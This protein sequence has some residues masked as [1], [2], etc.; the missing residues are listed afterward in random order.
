M[1]NQEKK[2]TIKDIVEYFK[3]EILVEGDLEQNIETNDIHRAGYELT[4]FFMDKDELKRAV[5]VMG[6]KESEYLSRLCQNR[7]DQI[8]DEYFSHKFPALVLSS[9]VKDIE[10]ILERARIY[11]KVVLKTKNR[12]TEFIRDLNNYLKNMLGREIIINEAILLDVYGMGVLLKGERDLK[13]GAAIE[14]IERGHKFISDQNILVKETARG[15]VGINTRALSEPEK[16]FYLLMGDDQEDINLTLNF[17]IVSNEMKKGIG[18]IVELE[19]W[20]EK[21]FYDRLGIDEVYENILGHP[22]KKVTLPARKGRNL[23]V[24]IETAAID[25]RLKMLGVNS[26]KYFMEESQKIILE[27]K[28]RKKRGENMDEKKISMEKF[29]KV[30]KLKVLYGEEYLKEHYITSTSITRP[31]MALS[32][33][34]NLEEEIYENKGLQLITNIELEYLKQLSPHKREENLEKFFSYNFPGMIICGDLELPEDFVDLVIKNKK[35]VLKSNER[36]PSRVIATLNTYLEQELAETLTVHGVFVEMYGLGILLTG[37]SGIGKSETALELIH[38]GHRL[39]A[40]DLVK[41]RKTPDGDVVGTASKLPFFMEIRGLGIIDIKTLYGLS[42]VVITKNIEAIIEIKEQ[43]SEDYL[44]RVNYSTGKD[45]ILDK[46]VYKA[47]LYMSSGRNAAA[48][49]EIVVMNLMAK[50]LGHT[51]ENAFMNLKGFL[52]K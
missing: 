3:L 4:G 1:I 21:K 24:V 8:L 41:F 34:F 33:Y 45:K 48:M 14:L 49:V 9:K 13:I 44:T 11:N 46:E 43:D 17:G 26:A 19:V 35:I 23:A 20:Q 18:L 51:K 10:H 36:T 12:T 31:S 22:I 28:A 16:D 38:R 37:K 30:N 27:K 25:S 47:E 39:V 29:T 6:H 5:H 7:R 52:N 42:S 15:L 50:K 32:G 2:V 40:D